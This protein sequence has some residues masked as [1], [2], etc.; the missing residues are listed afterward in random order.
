[1]TFSERGLK[2]DDMPEEPKKNLHAVAMAKL[3]AAS[4]TPEQRRANAR[5]AGHASAGIPRP[6]RRKRATA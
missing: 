3:Q 1:L 6:N 5:A 2:L 4:L